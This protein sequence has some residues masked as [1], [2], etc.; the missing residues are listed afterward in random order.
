[1]NTIS[2]SKGS[3]LSG[4][5]FFSGINRPIKPEYIG[6]INY[7][8]LVPLGFIDPSATEIVDAGTLRPPAWNANDT[9][10]RILFYDASPFT[11]FTPIVCTS[12]YALPEYPAAVL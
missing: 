7:I 3:K 10:Y 12:H 9:G 4:K 5:S 8:T 11:G 2:I 1:M 6:T